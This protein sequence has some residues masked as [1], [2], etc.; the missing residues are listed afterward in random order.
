MSNITN[1]A[2]RC[3]ALNLG[4]CEYKRGWRDPL[5]FDRVL[6]TNTTS[7]VFDRTQGKFVKIQLRR[8]GAMII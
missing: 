2:G 7:E 4:L 5:R 6:V 1:L 8:I 3:F